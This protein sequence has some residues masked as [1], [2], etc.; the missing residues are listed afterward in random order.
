MHIET[1]VPDNG[2]GLR[3]RRADLRGVEAQ[4]V[5]RGRVFLLGE[6]GNQLVVVVEEFGVFKVGNRL[7]G[8]EGFAVGGGEGGVVFVGGRCSFGLL[9]LSKMSNGM[10][11]TE[12]RFVMITSCRTLAKLLSGL[13]D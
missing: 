5:G 1:H 4:R 12:R 10:S 7:I 6:D 9:S 8:A 13:T 11:C 2:Q 3:Q